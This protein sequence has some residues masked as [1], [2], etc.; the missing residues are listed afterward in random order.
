M[1]GFLIPDFRPFFRLCDCFVWLFVFLTNCYPSRIFRGN[2]D[3][4]EPW[5]PQ[6]S[7]LKNASDVSDLL[8]EALAAE[9]MESEDGDGSDDGSDDVKMEE[10]KDGSTPPEEPEYYVINHNFAEEELRSLVRIVLR[11]ED[12]GCKATLRSILGM[13]RTGETVIKSNRQAPKGLFA[14]LSYLGLCAPS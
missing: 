10:E 7:D 8:D 9:D 3:A 11:V 14:F 13:Q 5:D 1:R 6:S 4:L 12:E 2:S